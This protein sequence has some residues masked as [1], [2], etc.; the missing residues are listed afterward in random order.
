[1]H[2]PN[3]EPLA[4]VSSQQ[5][6]DKELRQETQEQ[7]V[8]KSV[9]C[10]RRSEQ[11]GFVSRQ[12]LKH[13]YVESLGRDLAYVTE[14]SLGLW[15]KVELNIHSLVGRSKRLLPS[16]ALSIDAESYPNFFLRQ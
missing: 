9:C 3:E 11:S 1:M 4:D 14:I 12:S 7:S 15:V 16:S 2:S 6:P 13:V 10:E 8:K 5:L